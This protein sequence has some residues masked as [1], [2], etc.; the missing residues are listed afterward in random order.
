MTPGNI[1][2]GQ[3]GSALRLLGQVTGALEQQH[4]FVLQMSGPLPWRQSFYEAVEFRRASFGNQRRLVRKTWKA[5]AD[6]GE[7][8]L[9]EFCPEQVRADYWP[10]QSCGA[11]LGSRDDITLCSYYVWIT[12][13][14]RPSDLSAWAA[15]LA[16]YTRSASIPRPAAV[17]VLEYDGPQV[18]LTGMKVI[19]STVEHYDCRVFSLEA[20]GALANTEMRTYQAELALRLSQGN[21]EL[22]YALLERG[23]DLLRD[24]AGTAAEVSCLGSTS[25]GISFPS[26]APVQADSAAWEAALVLL[27]PLIE[28]FRMELIKK[29][30]QELRCH[31]PIRNSN[32]D[33]VRDPR[34][35]EIG[36]LSYIVTGLSREFSPEEVEAVK[37]CRKVRNLLAHN[38]MVPYEDVEKLFALSERSQ[39]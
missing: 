5:G 10:G 35:L 27:F 36:P 8:V 37:L 23:I 20:A 25:D 6:P 32:G 3:L 31:L 11:Y 9:E 12:G 30:E 33:V 39:R 18:E 29:R 4:S 1:W 34:D 16:D 2:W 28:R 7:F 38:R 21:P 24:P 19:H 22:C 26:I 15:F 14:D 13:L 17:F